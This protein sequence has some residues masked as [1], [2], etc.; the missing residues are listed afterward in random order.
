MFGNWFWGHGIFGL[1]LMALVGALLIS[2]TVFLVRSLTA[3]GGIHQDRKD[4]LEI[5][6]A[7]HAAGEIS[8]E[9][10]QRMREV[11]FS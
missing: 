2:L 9:E 6:K 4:S 10:Y 1:L 11:L 7:K 3:R 5:L 8:A